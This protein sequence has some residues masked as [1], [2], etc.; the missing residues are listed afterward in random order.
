MQPG[1]FLQ[2]F[3][4]VVDTDIHQLDR[5]QRTAALLRV[6]GRVSRNAVE[7][8]LHRHNSLG[9]ARPGAGLRR[10]MPV[11]ADVQI[12]EL[13]VKQHVDLADD[14]LFGRSAVKANRAFKVVLLHRRLDGQDSTQ[15]ARSQAAVTARMPGRSL[16][17]RRSNRF[18][19]LRHPGQRV[20][21]GK[22]PD[23]RFSGAVTRHKGRRHS[24]DTVLHLEPVFFQF[25]NEQL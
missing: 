12:V 16:F 1:V 20:V 22:N 9:T 21:F 11:Q 2:M 3:A 25:R 18:G 10:R 5:V 4:H 24:G 17:K 14:R 8:E 23:D 19:L 13:P 15:R 7:C 6:P